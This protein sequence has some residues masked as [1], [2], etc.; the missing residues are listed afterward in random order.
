MEPL[1]S[2]RDPL[3]R[4]PALVGAK[5]ARLARAVAVGAPVLE[6]W[7]LPVTASAPPLVAALEA[8]DRAGSPAA[9]LSVSSWALDRRLVSVLDRVARRL[10][11]TDGVREGGAHGPDDA[12]LGP[13]PS[14][15]IRS[16]TALDDDGRWA[17]AFTTYLDVAPQD[18]RAAVLGCWAS[19]VSRDV[20]ER[21][22]AFGVAPSELR[23]GILFQAFRAFEA[24]GTA[25]RAPDGRVAVSAVPGAPSA[26]LGGRRAAVDVEIAPG[27]SLD[28]DVVPSSLV[29]AIEAAVSL[30]LEVWAATGDD[31]IEWGT[32]G[33]EVLLLQAR[34]TPPPAPIRVV[35]STTSVELEPAAPWARRLAP[36]VTRYPAPLGDELV[37]PWALLG[38]GEIPE[39]PPLVVTD[40]MAALREATS[41][42]ER[43]AAVAWGIDDPTR[44]VE[45]ARHA[46][47]LVLGSAGRIEP[48]GPAEGPRAVDPTCVHRLLGL[49]GGIGAA[50]AASGVLPDPRAI[51]RVSRSEL[52]GALEGRRPPVRRGPDR[53]EP[54]VA[55]VVGAS[56]R[57]L[58]GE[59]VTPG[60]G[61]GRLRVLRRRPAHLP[62]PR[63]VL[64]A[65]R[66]APQLAPLLWNAAGLVIASGGAGAHLFE[67]ARS[68]GVPTV[69]GPDLDDAVDGSLVAVD[70]TNGTVS[71]LSTEREPS[72]VGAGDG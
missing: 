70:G 58:D 56:G 16:S 36:V 17:G 64:A 44:A 11:A 27:R 8:L 3:A 41:L 28:R 52:A 51:W 21:C 22:E 12:D 59:P 55:A 50:L 24:G 33:D 34:R 45:Q 67:V 72:S 43:L 31:A 54:F 65:P 6:G 39:S 69:L 2:L 48:S 60:T 30:L 37:V 23:V 26:L 19:A 47:R 1:L 13:S 61:A 62:E 53:W 25:R 68:L 71:I 29:P 7:V 57:R 42:V 32:V 15:A 38:A 20:L 66:P 4:D 18:L 49:I 63:A 40:G 14:L 10:G 46:A 5:A 9:T 35:R